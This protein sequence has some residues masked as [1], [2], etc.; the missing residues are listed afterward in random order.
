MKRI[1]I[2]FLILAQ[3]SLFAQQTINGNLDHDGVTRSYILYV[4]QAY[5][6][7]DAVPVVFNFHGFGSDAEQ[8]YYYADFRP[9]ADRENFLLVLPNGTELNGNQHWDVGGSIFGS[10]TDDVGFTAALLDELSAQYNIDHKR[11]YATGM[12]NGGYMSFHL[13]CQLPDRFAA[14]AS[15]TGAMTPNSRFACQVVRPFPVLQ[16]HGTEDP[17]V[18]YDGANWSISIP[19]VLDY[20]SDNNEVS[21]NPEIIQV[22][23]TNTT[24]QST[25]EHMI[26]TGTGGVTVEH[27]K[28]TGGE[29]TWP[30]API[31]LGVTNQ[32]INA[33]EEIWTFF[34]K[35]TLDG[36]VA[37]KEIEQ[38]A[39]FS[40]YPNP[41]YGQ[42]FIEKENNQLV[43]FQLTDLHGR[44]LKSGQLNN[45]RNLLDL[46]DFPPGMYYLKAGRKVEKVIK[47]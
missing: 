9:V 45:S 15:V 8:Q 18:P 20:W 41:T 44:I 47:Q 27:F 21:S 22:P 32:D 14:V 24:D 12:S 5:T 35:Y 38:V 2:G 23:N 25:V 11:V 34:K 30:G 42:L 40:V 36:L 39:N 29:H 13:A 3:T 43:Y 31:P 16:I 33:C 28:V 6:G 1:L 7:D 19:D 37:T 10:G 46:K 17:V 26:W 4:P